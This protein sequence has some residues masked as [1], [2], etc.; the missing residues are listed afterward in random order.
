MTMDP[1]A[2]KPTNLTKPVPGQTPT[3]SFD[4]FQA[5]MKM[6]SKPS[7]SFDDFVA[8][9]QGQQV[10]QPAAGAQ[11]ASPFSDLPGFNPMTGPI[12]PGSKTNYED[13]LGSPQEQYEGAKAGIALGQA[14]VG[15]EL[16]PAIIGPAAKATGK[17][18][19]KI[20]NSETATKLIGG[21][22]K[23]FGR[24]A[25]PISSP[26][27][28][29][30]SAYKAKFKLPDGSKVGQ[31]IDSLIERV[32][33]TPVNELSQA[34][35]TAITARLGKDAIPQAV[36]AGA[37]QLQAQAPDRFV[38]LTDAVS[39][40]VNAVGSGIKK[41]ASAVG[42]P[43][44]ATAKAAATIAGYKMGGIGGAL[45]GGVGTELVVNAI[46]KAP[47]LATKLGFNSSVTP[48]FLSRSVPR[49]MA[50]P[51]AKDIMLRHFLTQ[52]QAQAPETGQ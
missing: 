11:D 20:L 35:V 24:E 34:D 44:A 42:P 21:V 49:L 3:E 7:Q 25:N 5:R 23:L 33:A 1:Y 22:E 38:Q 17:Y 2:A 43:I 31:Q 10:Q 28:D 30:L 27:A 15:G 18:L 40:G 13:I 32:K 48:E 19:S 6:P 14:G 52:D 41:A 51:K 9:Q 12:R 46:K 29:S 47:A 8:Q 37:K 45:E 36:S 16:G 50:D 39:S 4:D 26:L